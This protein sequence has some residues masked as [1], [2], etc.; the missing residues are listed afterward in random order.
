M[1]DWQTIAIFDAL[2]KIAKVLSSIDKRLE[3]LS[4]CVEENEKRVQTED[5]YIFEGD[6]TYTFKVK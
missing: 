1:D 3:V 5:G 4:L 2:S 6:G